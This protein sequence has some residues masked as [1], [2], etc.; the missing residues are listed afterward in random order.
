MAPH[1]G[2]VLRSAGI[3]LVAGVV[4]WPPVSDLLYWSVFEG[5]GDAVILLVFAA[6]VAAGTGI[7][8]RTGVH[9]RSFAVGGT[10]AYVMVMGVWWAVCTFDSPV[11]LLV[12]GVILI[13][14]VLGIGVVTVLPGESEAPPDGED[15]SL[16]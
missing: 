1:L 11:H 8:T 7:G 9:P 5:I 2:D 13:G 14:L 16:P 12:Y 15:S 4:L 10:L 3:A 6:S